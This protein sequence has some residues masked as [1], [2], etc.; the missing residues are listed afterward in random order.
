MSYTTFWPGRDDQVQGRMVMA[1]YLVRV[2]EKFEQGVN[3]LDRG[4][5]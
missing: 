2:F 1:W 3:W 5:Y 4:H